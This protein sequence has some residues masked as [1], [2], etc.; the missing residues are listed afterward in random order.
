MISPKFLDVFV[1][2][3]LISL[4]V[5]ISELFQT[6]SPP[7]ETGTESDGTLNRAN[8]PL[9]STS[10]SVDGD[11]GVDVFYDLTECVVQSVLKIITRFS[12]IAV[13]ITD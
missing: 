2:L 13:K 1:A 4:G 3:C 6:E 8:H 7:V 12:F 9:G 5:G 11:D 10:S